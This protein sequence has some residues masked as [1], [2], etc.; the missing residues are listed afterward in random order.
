MSEQPHREIDLGN[1]LRMARYDT[2]IG[3]AVCDAQITSEGGIQLSYL[4]ISK[5]TNEVVSE[6]TT[7]DYNNGLR[8]I[9]VLEMSGLDVI[10][11]DEEPDAPVVDIPRPGEF[12][13]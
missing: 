5:H 13:L 3:A 10:R 6:T 2:S 12:D 9:K 1:T 4:L 7:H 8:T 11:F